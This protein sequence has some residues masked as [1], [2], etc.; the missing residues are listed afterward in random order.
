V[1]FVR[2]VSV[3]TSPVFAS[4]SH[5]FRPSRAYWGV[6]VQWSGL[7]ACV[8]LALISLV[9]KEERERACGKNH[10]VLLA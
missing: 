10:E 5:P 2:V 4:V 8:V 7:L 3:E 6:A 9:G 1:L